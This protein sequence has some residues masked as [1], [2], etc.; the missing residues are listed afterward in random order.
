MLVNY[1]DQNG[2]ITIPIDVT[3]FPEI[4]QATALETQLTIGGIA[5]EVIHYNPTGL[6]SGPSFEVDPKNWALA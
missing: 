5:G 1:S 2:K 4:A 3:F 6:S